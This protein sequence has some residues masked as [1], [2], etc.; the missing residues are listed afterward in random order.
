MRQ[1]MEPYFARH[2]I[3][4][5]QWGVLRTLH[6]A[7][8]EHGDGLVLKD[9]GDRMLVRPPSMTG[10]VDRLN[11]EGYVRKSVARDDQR[12]RKV[13]LTAAGRNLVNRVLRH[14]PRQIRCV[15]S[16][17]SEADARE[18]NR[19][20]DLVSKSLTPPRTVGISEVNT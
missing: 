10:V 6:R 3:S 17:L 5:A 7:E 15:L 12:A 4:G 18:L 16:A 19:L 13:V 11:R 1:A 2:G 20:M 9:L 14:H 8:R